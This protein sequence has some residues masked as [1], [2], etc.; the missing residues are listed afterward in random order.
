MSS[1][2]LPMLRMSSCTLPSTKSTVPATLSLGPN[3]IGTV[4][5]P[6]VLSSFCWMSSS[7]SHAPSWR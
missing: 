2:G 6:V 3:V 7:F 5:T 4:F 1:S